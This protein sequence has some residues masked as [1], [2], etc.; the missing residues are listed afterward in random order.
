MNLLRRNLP[1]LLT[2]ALLAVAVPASAAT[3]VIV[4][5]NAAGVGFN[6]PTPVAPVGGNPGTTLGAQRLFIFQHAASIWGALLDSPATILVRA[7]FV[8]QTCTPTSA[9]LGSAG[10]LTAHRD[11]A[12]AE[13]ANTWYH[14]SLANK[15]FGAD[16]DGTNPDINA[17]FNLALDSGACLGGATWYYGIDGNE[18]ANVELLPVVLH[19]LGHGLNFSTLTNGSTGALFNSFPAIWDRFLMNNQTGLHWY[20]MSNAQRQA[21][22]ISTGNLVWDGPF[23]TA[24]APSF[25]SGRPQMVIN[26]PGGI[27]G[28]TFNV[29]TATFGPSTFN[30]TGDVVLVDDGVAP[31]ADGCEPIVN[32]LTGKIALIDRGLCT[33]VIKAKAAQDAGAI[34][35][36]IANNVASGLPGMGGTDPTITIPALGISQADGNTI[37]ANLGTGVNVTMNF[38]PTLLAGADDAGLVRMYAP[39]PFQGGSSVSHFDVT[40]NP[41]ALMEPAI[42]NDLHDTVDLTLYLFADIGWMPQATSTEL[43]MFLAEG[44]RDGIA[45]RWRFLDPTDVTSVAVERAM[46]ADG[47]FEAI[48]VELAN[49]G[50]IGTALD[51]GALPSVTYHYRLRVADRRGEISYMGLASA[52]R[53]DV[54]A[55]GVHLAAPQ[56]N[57]SRHSATFHFAL[58]QA[59][60]VTLSVVDAGGRLV[61]TLESGMMPAGEYTRI[62]DGTSERAGKVPA[63]LYFVQLRTSQGLSTHRLAFIR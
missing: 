17:N 6:D 20:Q 16:L 7:Q 19:E 24:A 43:T 41:N 58:G 54:L 57:P 18:G 1:A 11:F 40:L 55:D 62:W 12:G 15:L 61:R 2:A 21:S 42:N 33:F 29:Q 60:H 22:A 5:N 14:A 13:Y 36:L 53:L 49:E 32:D 63:G 25:L 38:H 47:P 26:S 31:N 39:N 44:R 3:I 51:T 8:N 48:P 9:T 52:Q 34:A 27:A 45:L 30:V 23:T 28:S 4:N 59:E 37:K 46:A 35:V 56:P 50:E 10:P